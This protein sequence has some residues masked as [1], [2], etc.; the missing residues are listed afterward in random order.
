LAK[1]NRQDL[2][3][4]KFTVTES[5]E[6]D[7]EHAGE[8]AYRGQMYDV[9]AVEQHADTLW[10]WCLPDVR[11]TRINRQLEAL[12]AQATRHNPH[13]KDQQEWLLT[14]LKTLYCRP[15]DKADAAPAPVHADHGGH[16]QL[17]FAAFLTAPPVP[18]PRI[19]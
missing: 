3:L 14:F 8:F 11:E 7:W 10:Y 9:A 16:I 6:L 19:A 15:T 17:I 4:M 13:T 18:P 12:L 1:A 2:V 5:Y